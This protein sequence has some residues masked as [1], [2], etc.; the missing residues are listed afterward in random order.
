MKSP[1]FSRCPGTAVAPLPEAGGL[2]QGPLV[3]NETDDVAT[4]LSLQIGIERENS[5]VDITGEALQ[6][7]GGDQ[8]LKL[9]GRIMFWL[10]NGSTP[11]TQN[12]S[13]N[14]FKNHTRQNHGGKMLGI[15]NLT[16][17]KAVATK[18]KKPWGSYA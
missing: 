2:C 6:V 10:E 16:A 12:N 9:C 18:S 5:K 1:S 7:L 4:L 17:G 15:M 3:G 11:L 13:I 14:R 8:V